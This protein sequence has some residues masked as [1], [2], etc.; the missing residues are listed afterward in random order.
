MEDR[1]TSWGGTN[2]FALKCRTCGKILYGATLCQEEYNRQY[3]AWQKEEP[4]R[5]RAA[6]AAAREH[7]ERA[8]IARRIAQAE[9]ARRV[10]QQRRQ[11]EEARRREAE[12]RAWIAKSRQEQARQREEERS[13][14]AE[15]KAR[16]ETEAAIRRCSWKDC[17]EPARPTS[18]YCSRNCSNKNARWRHRLRRERQQQAA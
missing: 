6:E 8:E 17:N 5:R 14:Q 3:A 15:Q 1:A 4:S 9:R 2:E 12:A 13:A 18:I 16:E 10:Q 11:E 7:E